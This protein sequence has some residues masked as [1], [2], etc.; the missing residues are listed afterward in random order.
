MEQQKKRDC[1]EGI[2]REWPESGLS[3]E[4]IAFV[5]VYPTRHFAIGIGVLDQGTQKRK[6][7]GEFAPSKFQRK[8]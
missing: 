3:R 8:R 6:R 5:R 4:S 7:A 1:W 2:I